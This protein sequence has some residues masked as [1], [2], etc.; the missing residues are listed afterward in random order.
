MSDKPQVDFSMFEEDDEKTQAQHPTAPE[1]D[2]SMFD[3]EPSELPEDMAATSPADNSGQYTADMDT[4]PDPSRIST[5]GNFW[6]SGLRISRGEADQQWEQHVKEAIFAGETPMPRSK[7]D[8]SLGL[9]G[10]TYPD[11]SDTDRTRAVIAKALDSVSGGL[12]RKFYESEE[13]AKDSMGRPNKSREAA[14]DRMTADV[15]KH[16]PTSSKVADFLGNMVPATVGGNIARKSVEGLA[17][18]AAPIIQKYAP[19]MA[20]AAV[21]SLPF[22]E[23]PEEAAL[24][25][26]AGAVIAPPMQKAGEVAAKSFGKLLGKNFDDADYYLRNRDRINDPK[27]D[28]ESVHHQI[29]NVAQGKADDVARAG[30]DLTSAR[31]AEGKARD[32]AK[33]AQAEELA[34]LRGQAKEVPDEAINR[35]GKAISKLSNKTK[36]LSKAQREMLENMDGQA[37]LRAM[38]DEIDNSIDAIKIAG[39]VT[40]NNPQYR[41]LLIFK[42]LLDDVPA[43]DVSPAD[44]LKVRQMVDDVNKSAFNKDKGDFTSKGEALGLKLRG[45]ANKEL[46]SLP[47]GP[48]YSKTRAE[49]SKN[50]GLQNRVSRKFGKD[51]PTSALAGAATNP[52]RKFDRAMLKSLDRQTGERVSDAL[53]PM[54]DADELLKNPKLKQQA[55]DSLD[56]SLAA[57]TAEQGVQTADEQLRAAK[58]A[59]KKLGIKA[60]DQSV[61]SLMASWFTK[62]PD[63]RPR[64]AARKSLENIGKEAGEDMVQKM[65][66]LV[67]KDVYR[68]AR[69]QGSRMVQLAG[70][71]GEAAG[72]PWGRAGGGLAG[73]ILDWTGGKVAKGMLDYAAAAPNTLTK[74]MAVWGAKTLT[75]AARNFSGESEQAK[76]LQAAAQQGPEVLYAAHQELMQTDKEYAAKMGDAS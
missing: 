49:L 35:L 13:L 18:N 44:M 32:A 75:E 33:M 48:E 67:V 26:A 2:F 5:E 3:D 17:S 63:R 46:D 38:R 54:K 60:D 4:E 66:D 27:L 21:G 1:P 14:L 12:G 37:S 22:A 51:D 8:K 29:K 59:L 20:D 41:D 15:E 25:M 68:A 76:K 71:V 43:N 24:G 62:N 52:N 19:G 30:D 9:R 23:S 61:E 69:P 74:S 73:G 57:K 65:D 10:V 31:Y 58:E 72:G 6:D 36:S 28:F 40:E 42:K 50:A 16:K 55:L 56:E 45:E 39:E 53:L 64:I 7:F 47:G 11:A 34:K 70:N